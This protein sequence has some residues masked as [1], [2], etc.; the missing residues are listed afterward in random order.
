MRVL[1][2]VDLPQW[3][4]YELFLGSKSLSLVISRERHTAFTEIKRV[5]GKGGVPDETTQLYQKAREL[6]GEE[7]VRIGPI[8]YTFETF[9]PK[10][11]AWALAPEKGG[12]VFKWKTIKQ[13]PGLLIASVT[14]D[15]KRR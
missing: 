9:S 14:I 6:M 10:M 1:K 4:E 8:T 3:L 13:E 7:A 2:E 15:G 5:K 11:E 12:K